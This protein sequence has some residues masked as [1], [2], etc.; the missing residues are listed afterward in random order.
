MYV[1]ERLGRFNRLL[2]STRGQA[3]L[4]IV[5]RVVAAFSTRRADFSTP[6]AGIPYV[7]P[8][9]RCI[10]VHATWSIAVTDAK[11]LAYSNAPVDVDR[12]TRRLVLDRLRDA[13]MARSESPSLDSPRPLPDLPEAVRAS[14]NDTTTKYGLSCP[15]F[16]I[17]SIQTTGAPVTR[18]RSLNLAHAPDSRNPTSHEMDSVLPELPLPQNAPAANARLHPHMI[19]PIPPLSP[20]P[21]AHRP[22][23]HRPHPFPNAFPPLPR[24]FPPPPPSQLSSHLPPSSITLHPPHHPLPSVQPYVLPHTNKLPVSIKYPQPPNVT[25][26]K[27]TNIVPSSSHLVDPDDKMSEQSELL[28][29]HDLQPHSE[30]NMNPLLASQTQSQSH[31]ASQT[32]SAIPRKPL[33]APPPTPSGH[34]PMRPPALPSRLLPMLVSRAFTKSPAVPLFDSVSSNEYRPSTNTPT[35]TSPTLARH[36]NALPPTPFAELPSS[37]SGSE[38]ATD[39]PD[40]VRGPS[41]SVLSKLNGGFSHPSQ[42]VDDSIHMDSLR[43]AEDGRSDDFDGIVQPSSLTKHRVTSPPPLVTHFSPPSTPVSDSSRPV[44]HDVLRGLRVDDDDDDDNEYDGGI[45]DDL[46]ALED[47]GDEDD[48][49]GDIS[50]DGDLSDDDH[51][52]IPLSPVRQSSIELHQRRRLSSPVVPWPSTRSVNP[53]QATPVDLQDLPGRSKAVPLP[54]D[55]PAPEVSS[56]GVRSAVNRLVAP[57][58]NRLPSSA[59]KGSASLN[60]GSSTNTESTLFEQSAL[61]ARAQLPSESVVREI[62]RKR[63]PANF[64]RNGSESSSFNNVGE[65]LSSIGEKGLSM[66]EQLRRGKPTDVLEDTDKGH[67]S[68]TEGLVMDVSSNDGSTDMWVD[69]ASDSDRENFDDE[70][71]VRRVLAASKRRQ[72]P[73]N[74]R[75]ESRSRRRTTGDDFDEE[76]EVSSDEEF[77]RDCGHHRHYNSHK[78]SSSQRGGKSR[79]KAKKSESDKEATERHFDHN[80]SSRTRAK[81]KSKISARGDRYGDS[82]KSDQSSKDRSQRG[83]K[84]LTR[85]SKPEKE[86][87]SRKDRTTDKKRS[88]SKG[89]SGSS[90]TMKKSARDADVPM[91]KSKK[92]TRGKSGVRQRKGAHGSGTTTAAGH[93]SSPLKLKPIYRHRE[94]D[95]GGS[96]PENPIP[97]YCEGQSEPDDTDL[98]DLAQL[99]SGD[100]DR[101]GRILANGEK[102]PYS[103]Y[104]QRDRY[105]HRRR[106]RHDRKVRFLY[107]TVC[108]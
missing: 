90:S 95:S 6:P 8:N 60:I 71:L 64:P 103:S 89:R 22:L 7:L 31:P 101:R 82:R 81:T 5:D 30:S 19:H 4:P 14:V 37:E 67:K 87:F 32:T 39:N 49:D 54:A 46:D 78:H 55:T 43:V 52:P 24:P 63:G 16:T 84:G 25:P 41:A 97:W 34:G 11:H 86:I 75:N 93:V 53:N 58:S 69:G 21:P 33:Y 1:V 59:T 44:A 23:S 74:N 94:P 15:L 104:G 26:I 76:D 35:A 62:T 18:N 80:L 17:T 96:G 51:L 48:L 38:S 102:V 3:L 73:S 47:T 99:G 79:S 108:E 66:S 13:V 50:D 88:H 61:R 56:Q 28:D 98:E 68:P 65:T 20:L 57:Q 9:S 72:K 77:C 105:G 10:T 36:L 70:A 12:F 100:V 107:D 42:G 29:R 2:H 85:D 40:I 83:K 27:P 106:A 92:E 45:D 91:E